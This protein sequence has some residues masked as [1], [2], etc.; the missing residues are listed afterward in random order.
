MRCLAP[1]V[2]LFGGCPIP[3][4]PP[5]TSAGANQ[6]V[7]VLPGPKDDTWVATVP[8]PVANLAVMDDLVGL[9][10]DATKADGLTV[11][12]DC[13]ATLS[14]CLETSGGDFTGCV[15]KAPVCQ[16]DT[17]WEEGVCCPRACNEAFRASV[18]AGASPH[19]AWLDSFAG[20]LSCFPGVEPRERK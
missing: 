12:A 15:D 11:Y 18:S 2:L 17:P 13:T 10:F 3:T 8:S 7:E 4:S 9:V 16:T 5:G 14:R 19:D 20:T 6:T 1:L